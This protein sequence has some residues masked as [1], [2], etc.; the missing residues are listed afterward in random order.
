MGWKEDFDK[1][2]SDDEMKR[3]YKKQSDSYPKAGDSSPVKKMSIEPG[4][5][6]KRIYKK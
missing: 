2:V 5:K 4:K 3:G 6:K 1:G